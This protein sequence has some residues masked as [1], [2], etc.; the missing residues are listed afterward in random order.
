MKYP[1][2]PQAHPDSYREPMTKLDKPYDIKNK[3]I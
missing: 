1:C 2:L 3:I